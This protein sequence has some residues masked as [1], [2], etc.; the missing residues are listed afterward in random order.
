MYKKYIEFNVKWTINWYFLKM[1]ISPL[2]IGRRGSYICYK[3]QN[4]DLTLFVI[5]MWFV[6][7]IFH[8]NFICKNFLID[9]AQTSWFVNIL[10][11]TNNKW[12]QI[13]FPWYLTWFSFNY[14]FFFFLS[15]LINFFICF[16]FTDFP[17]PLILF[18]VGFCTSFLY[19]LLKIC[20]LANETKVLK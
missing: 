8:N 9:L 5:I 4:K 16:D 13:D 17:D 10:F 14:L 12:K 11:I 2:F 6:R 18:F 3:N 19:L 20:F 15:K 7:I 1:K